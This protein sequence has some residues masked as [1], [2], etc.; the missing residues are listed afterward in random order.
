MKRKTKSIAGAV[1]ALGL[2]AGVAAPALA[3]NYSGTKSCPTNYQVAL[4]TSLDPL[5]ANS[6]SATTHVHGTAGGNFTTGFVGLG[7]KQSWS[8]GYT[9]SSYSATSAPSNPFYTK[10]VSCAYNGV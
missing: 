3:D 7:T 9:T 8:H 10:S 2:V 5:Y 6:S 1:L 4:S